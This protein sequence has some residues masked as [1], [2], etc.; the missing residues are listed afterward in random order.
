MD[1]LTI[2][3]FI[4]CAYLLLN[5]LSLNLLTIKNN[6]SVPSPEPI[7]DMISP[8]PRPNTAAF[9]VTIATNGNTG[10]KLSINVL[11]NPT[12]IVRNQ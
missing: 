4:V 3:W 8:I 12:I 7:Q 9:I 5:L 11:N 1:S 2:I 10:K 6:T